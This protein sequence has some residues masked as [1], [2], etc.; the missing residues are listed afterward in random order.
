MSSVSFAPPEKINLYHY[1]GLEVFLLQSDRYPVH[2]YAVREDRMAVASVS[3][4]QGILSGIQIAA[5]PDIAWLDEQDQ[6]WF[7]R[8]IEDHL[9]EI[10]KS[11]IDVYVYGKPVTA[12]HLNKQIHI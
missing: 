5:V 4:Q 12:E 7:R 8:I 11:W 6:C 3:F 10:L 1:F 9:S 2:V